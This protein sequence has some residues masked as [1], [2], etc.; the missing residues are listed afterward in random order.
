MVIRPSVTT[1]GLASR[2]Q[3]ALDDGQRL[4]VGRGGKNQNGHHEKWNRSHVILP[5]NE[6][7]VRQLK[8]VLQVSRRSTGE[9]VTIVMEDEDEL[10]PS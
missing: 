8:P 7:A 3:A 10:G 4:C 1:H 6:T 9:S 2:K 5:R